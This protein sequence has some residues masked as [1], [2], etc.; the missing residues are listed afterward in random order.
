MPTIQEG[1]VVV[2][3]CGRDKGRRF[4]VLACDP[5]TV[6]LVDGKVRRLS[7]PKRK[8]RRHVAK[9]ACGSPLVK[10]SLSTGT[11]LT[12][13]ALRRTLSALADG[14]TR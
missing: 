3:L 10:D 11:P 2:S 14:Q 9:D 8:N 12:D 1:D 4:F 6:A 7:R 5:Q 13:A